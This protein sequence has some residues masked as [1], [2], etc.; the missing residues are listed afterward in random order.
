MRKTK[1]KIGEKRKKKFEGGR[2]KGKDERM[3]AEGQ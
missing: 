3:G 2:M 1:K